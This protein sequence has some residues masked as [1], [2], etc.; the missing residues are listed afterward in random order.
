MITVQ[1]IFWFSLS[2]IL[3]SYLLFP[4]ILRLLA[5]KRP[6]EIQQFLPSELP[7]ISVL[8]AA[9]NEEKVIGEKIRSVLDGNYPRELLEI[10]V[11][12]DASTDHT[13][14][15]LQQLQEK[16]PALH[17]TIFAE[18]QGKPG[19]INQLAE[20]ASGEILVITDANVILDRDTLTQ[21][22]CNFK[23]E[24]TGLVDSRMVNPMVN[25]E[26]I[27]RQ[28]S[29]YISR[30][31]RIKHHESLIWGSMMGPFGGCYAVR[32]SLYQPVP[33]KF[34]VDDFFINMCVLKQGK[35]C[36]SKL[37]A[38][39]YEQA[40]SDPVEEFRR[41]KRI[42]AG[43]FQNLALFWPLIFKR[44]RG[45]GFCFFSHKVI[46][47]F[48]PFLV[49]ITFASSILLGTRS[50]FYLC[51]AVVHLGVFLTPVIIQFLRKIR[52]QSI[53]LRFVSHF[54]LMNLAL[55]AGFFRY[56]GGINNNVWQPTSRNQ[57]ETQFH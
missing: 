25:S 6:S 14:Q 33:E 4:E 13:N 5:R 29:F 43:N 12:S 22:I 46:R 35:S 18:R 30:E 9:F 34:L 10:L 56:L 41:K 28:E 53:P 55:L 24:R 48:V 2:L 19:I 54:V 27:S 8:I 44:K 11:A 36:I 20:K 16:H 21:L 23:E 17:L 32:K 42:S 47:W 7:S 40:S 49:M 15:I 45:I 26:G 39:V 50:G 31:V 37:E 51:L 52:I 38:I 57:D 3:Y 1:L